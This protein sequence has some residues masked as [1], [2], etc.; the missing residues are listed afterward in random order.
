MILNQESSE[1]LQ[2]LLRLVLRNTINVANMVS[3]WKNALPTCSWIGP[4][5]RV[6][7]LQL[8]ADVFWGTTWFGVDWEAVAFR[9]FVEVRLRKGD[10]QTL[11]EFLIWLRNAVV[12]F[13]AGCKHSVYI[14]IN[15][16]LLYLWN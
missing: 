8:L 1:E 3:N 15:R 9:D 2:Q 16:S 10:C 14:T 13:I 7:G 11:K 12:D 6:D 5:D 4:H